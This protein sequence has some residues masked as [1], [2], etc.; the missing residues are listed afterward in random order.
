MKLL[1]KVTHKQAIELCDRFR[2]TDELY[3]ITEWGA[4]GNQK[5]AKYVLE[6]GEETDDNWFGDISFLE[7]SKDGVFVRL[8]KEK[9]KDKLP[10]VEEIFSTKTFYPDGTI[11]TKH[12]EKK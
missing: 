12:P 6:L 4:C 1:F 10:N 8:K 11:I 9:Y 2:D 3:L 7:T 5:E